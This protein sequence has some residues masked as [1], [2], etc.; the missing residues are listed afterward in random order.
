MSKSQEK[1][2]VNFIKG[3]EEISKDLGYDIGTSEPEKMSKKEIVEYLEKGKELEKLEIVFFN[4]FK[5]NL[6]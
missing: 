6:K 3:I 4:W 2:F 5:K 1:K